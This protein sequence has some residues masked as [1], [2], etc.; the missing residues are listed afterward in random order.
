MVEVHLLR[1]GAVFIFSVDSS[2]IESLKCIFDLKVLILVFQI[3]AYH[4]K[5]FKIFSI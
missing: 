4:V 3:V 5:R 1:H 2:I